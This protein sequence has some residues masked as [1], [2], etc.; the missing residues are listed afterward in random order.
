MKR[1]KAGIIAFE[2]YLICSTHAIGQMPLKID[3]VSPQGKIV[4]QVFR[5]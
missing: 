2:P 3:L 5:D 1:S 4:N